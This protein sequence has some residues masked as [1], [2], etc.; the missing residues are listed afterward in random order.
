MIHA[1]GSLRLKL[2]AEIEQV[3]EDDRHIHF[4]TSAAWHKANI[5]LQPQANTVVLLHSVA[6]HTGCAGVAFS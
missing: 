5:I 4:E 3:L 2:I 1:V 6:A